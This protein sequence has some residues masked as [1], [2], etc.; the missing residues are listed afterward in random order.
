MPRG[1]GGGPPSGTG[2]GGRMSGN[3]PGAGPSGYC[4][5]P[6]CGEKV[7][8]A[9]GVPCYQQTCPKCGAKMMRS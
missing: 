2:G 4:V 6:Q 9:R 7:S 1:D 5:C 8:H 3:R